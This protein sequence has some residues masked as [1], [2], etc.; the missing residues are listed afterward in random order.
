MTRTG[1]T[2]LAAQ[3]RHQRNTEAHM[4]ARAR[5]ARRGD[6]RAR[7]G[8]RRSAETTRARARILDH[9]LAREQVDVARLVA[10][11]RV[12]LARLARVMSAHPEGI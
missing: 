11:R 2:E 8:Q 10:Q 5:K 4:A 9:L 12:E 7:E 6:Q 1:P 3:A